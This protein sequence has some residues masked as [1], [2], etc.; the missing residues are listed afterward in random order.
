MRAMSFGRVVLGLICL[1]A[2]IGGT[3]FAVTPIRVEG[4]VVDAQG[5]AVP[6]AMVNLDAAKGS[7]A[8]AHTGPDGRFSLVGGY[9]VGGYQLDIS[10][11]G[12]LPQLRRAPGVA[13]LQRAPIVEGRV[14]DETGAA[15]PGA[16]VGVASTRGSTSGQTVTDADGFFWIT[17]LRP[18]AAEVTVLAPDHDPWQVQVALGA[19]HI[20]QL[21]PIAA[22]QF[23]VLDLSTGPAGLA[24][25][26]DG[27]PMPG[28]AATPCVASIPVG[29]HQLT[30]DTPNYVP[31]S[32]PLSLVRS[33][34]LTVSAQLERK[35]GVLVVTVPAA[36]DAVLLVDGNQVAP[37]GW[38]G[39][40]PTG[41]HT[42]E[43]RSSY[44]WPWAGSVDVQWQQQS[45]LAV[46]ATAIVPGDQAAFVAGLDAYLS[47]L[48]GQYGVW[49]EDLNSGRQIA[50]HG[51]DSMEAASVIKLP[52]ALYLLDQARQG[53][54]NLTDT[55]QLQ[56]GDFMGG[57][58]TLYNGASS[59]DS[60]SYQ[61]LLALLIQ[62][63][64][65][66][67]WQ[68][69]D[70]VLG[71][72]NVDAYAASIGAPD[73]HQ[74]DDNCTSQE[75]GVMLAKLASGTVLDASGRQQLLQLLETTVFNDRIN[76]YL[77]GATI[78]HKVG[79]DGG[80]MNDAGIVYTGHPFVISM[81]TDGDNPD[82][83]V[84]A[85]RDVARAAARY[86]SR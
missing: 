27:Q 14:L 45:R 22:R 81:F 8:S 15:V 86:Y 59:G 73:C 4:R 10:A 82:Q 41:R 25:A 18:G 37:T 74:G 50:Y 35:K 48:G 46:A 49:L 55:V 28:C 12:F 62:Q 51:T 33:Q 66:T 5:R 21:A 11:S 16:W 60:Y 9:R 85:I 6:D 32:Q 20:E 47:S 70:R 1:T 63:S 23:G 13:V 76:Y 17:G 83:G 68:A 56:D 39:E 30:I 29:D 31:W 75:A 61:D 67:A 72:D 7:D 54:L 58:G 19:D 36:A 80:V 57:T 69:L 43:F 24:P 44:H 78:A 79:M 64:D 3:G 84:Q 52:L 38:S 26:L 53:K 2:M 42:V 34:R 65:N 40:L 71:S 77:G